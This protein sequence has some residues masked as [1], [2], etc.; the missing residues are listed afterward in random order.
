[1]TALD[2]FVAAL[3]KADDAHERAVTKADADRDAQVAALAADLQK[4][5]DFHDAAVAGAEHARKAALDAAGATRAEALSIANRKF[6]DA[7]RKEHGADDAFI[8]NRH[9]VLVL[10]TRRVEL[11]TATPV[12][13]GH[14][15]ISTP[16]GRSV[17]MA[18]DPVAARAALWD[19]LAADPVAVP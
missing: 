7:K 11:G 1:M 17:F 2:T 10:R 18:P 9:G 6:D 4:F 19:T 8:V 15:R 14:W 12:H 5:L 16:D 13:A 3:A